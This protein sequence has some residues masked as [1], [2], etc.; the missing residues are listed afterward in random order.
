MDSQKK[1]YEIGTAQQ[2][3]T[4]NLNNDGMIK[5]SCVATITGAGQGQETRT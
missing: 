3:Q 5:I 2:K 4:L 1:T